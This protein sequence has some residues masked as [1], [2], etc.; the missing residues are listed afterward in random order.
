MHYSYINSVRGIAI[1]MVI[2]CHVAYKFEIHNNN[3]EWLLGYGRMGVQLF[4]IASAYTLCLSAEQRQGEKNSIYRFYVRRYFRIFPVYY[5]GIV[6]YFLVRLYFNDFDNF[7][8]INITI[9]LLFLQG[10]APSV[11][12]SIVPGGWSIGIEMLFYSIF[13]FLFIFLNK[14]N[15]LLK[16]FILIVINSIIFYFIQD[17]FALDF[18]FLNLNILNNLP[19][20]I[21]GMLF[22]RYRK[23]AIFSKKILQI[24]CFLS[25]TFLS[26]LC[27]LC[28]DVL[29]IDGNPQYFKF[30]NL[31][32]GVSFIFLFVL[33]EK[34]KFLNNLIFQQVGVNSYSMY[35]L[36]FLPLWVIPTLK[37]ELV[38]FPL[39][40]FI[41][42]V[43]YLLSIP[44]VRFI[45]T[46]FIKLGKKIINRI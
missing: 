39:F 44:S 23:S 3:L 7:T 2:M 45:E 11:N 40:L 9:N 29:V 25:F 19:V 24:M 32:S 12:N 31:F 10:L 15:G 22:Y 43:T 4:F 8:F 6:L 21:V 28:K 36:H 14:G 26:Y 42:I 27:Y 41:T 18:D 30:I 5:F 34:S 17:L 33:V 16:G 35:I 20:F 46:P 37:N 38:I 13:P 1:L